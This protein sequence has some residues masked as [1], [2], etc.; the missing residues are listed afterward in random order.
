[1]S[2]V[3]GF[4]RNIPQL[5]VIVAH[6]AGL[7]TAHVFG[8]SI[9]CETY[10]LAIWDR[11]HGGGRLRVAGSDLSDGCVARARAGAYGVRE[12]DFYPDRT[13]TAEKI[14][15]PFLQREGERYHVA[16]ELREACAFTQLDVLAPPDRARVAAVD[17]LL[18]QNTLI[19]LGPDARRALDGLLPLVRPG[20]LMAIA[21]M[22]LDLRAAWTREN[23]LEP[24]TDRC[25]EI[26]DGWREQ[27]RAWDGRLA[28][29]RPHYALEPFTDRPDGAFRYSTLFRRR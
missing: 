17:L 26:H 6:A 4:F 14:A 29:E 8:C 12:V 15:A 3:T 27:R 23:G 10:S 11:L 16:P 28:G 19:H 22:D 1:M 2:H 13:D 5:D 21:G 20:G 25:A 7:G 18:C 24:I 9:G